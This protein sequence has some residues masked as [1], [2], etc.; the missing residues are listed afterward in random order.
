VRV[1]D[2]DNEEA[3]RKATLAVGA[4][5]NRFHLAADALE[6]YIAEGIQGIAHPRIDFP[7]QYLLARS[8]ADLRAAMLLA[9]SGFVVQSAS[10][11]RPVVEAINLVRLF[12]RDSSYATAWLRGDK[13]PSPPEVRKLLGE[14]PDAVYGHLAKLSHP[15]L[16]GAEQ[17]TYV[18]AASG[19][20][21]LMM[22]GL[23]LSDPSVLIAA[24]MPGDLLGELA[25]AAGHLNV[26]EDAALRWPSMLVTVTTELLEGAR[27]ILEVLHPDGIPPGSL[28]EKILMAM[29]ENVASARELAKAMDEAT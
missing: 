12:E 23:P 28:G 3:L 15:R 17:S 13:N 20:I 10:V 14:G 11:M 24:S 22:G 21:I 2:V 5:E 18:N 16:F 6:S 1:V 8:L 25:S 29:Q 7:T 27:G 26:N 9:A 19:E 4:A